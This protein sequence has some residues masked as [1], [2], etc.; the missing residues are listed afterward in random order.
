VPRLE[1]HRRHDATDVTTM[2]REKDLHYANSA[3]A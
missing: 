1:E 2:S 3:V